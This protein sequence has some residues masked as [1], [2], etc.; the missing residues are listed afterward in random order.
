MSEPS[1]ISR[2]SFFR[3]TGQ[4][5]LGLVY[6]VFSATCD[7]LEQAFPERIRPPGAIP[8]SEFVQR[9]RRCGACLKAC[10]AHAIVRDLRPD[11]FDQG[12]PYLLPR[13]AWC[14]MCHNFPCIAACPT[15]ALQM[16]EPPKMATTNGRA[17]V[18]ARFCLRT[19][20]TTCNHCSG[21]CP[22]PVS[23]LLMPSAAHLPPTVDPE[24]CVGCGA[25]EAA[26]PAFPE[27]A[28][29]VCVV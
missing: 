5:L 29:T 9:C 27:P 19:Q 2:R 10:P 22:T 11:S 15:G 26:C 1:S 25:C 8:E 7:T 3:A 18:V 28:V 21:R 4:G 6:E 12:L 16:P 23:A 17:R 14:R 24:V 13:Q 20:E